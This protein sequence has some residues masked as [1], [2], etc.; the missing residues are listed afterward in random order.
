MLEVPQR[1][2]AGHELVEVGDR[3]RA[4]RD[5]I[6][7]GVGDVERSGEPPVLTA[8]PEVRIQNVTEEDEFVVLGCDG[9]WGL[10][11]AALFL[12]PLP[13]FPPSSPSLFRRPLF[14]PPPPPLLPPSP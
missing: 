12:F 7:R 1:L 2:S 10:V 9:L 14:R 11:P 8:T 6:A 5:D 3:Q 13:S 4:R